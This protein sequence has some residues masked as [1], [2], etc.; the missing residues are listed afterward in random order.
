VYSDKVLMTS[1]FQNLISNALKYKS[2]RLLKIEIWADE[3]PDD[4]LFAVRDNGIGIDPKNAKNIF[5]VFKRIE[6]DRAEGA[7][8]GLTTCKRVIE[9]LGG[10]IWVESE[11]NK[12]STFYFTIPKREAAS[13]P[14]ASNA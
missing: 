12:G 8:I 5:E 13:M 1:L 6:P 3:R 10:R 2:E 14:L 11:K 9:H 4:F 7:G